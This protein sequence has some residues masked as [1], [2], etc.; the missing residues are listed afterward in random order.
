[1][2]VFLRFGERNERSLGR[3]RNVTRDI[4]RGLEKRRV[5]NFVI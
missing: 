5:S 2:R 4:I 1:M 3:A